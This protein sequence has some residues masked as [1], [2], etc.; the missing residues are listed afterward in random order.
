VE[1]KLN[2]ERNL[3]LVW[4]DP[5]RVEQVLV[6]LVG[7]AIRYTPAGHVEIRAWAEAPLLWV[8]IA[9]TGIG[10]A[11]EDLPLV[12]ERFWRADRSRDRQSGG[13][14]IGLAIS[15]RLVELQGG[16]IEVESELGVGSTFCFSL[17]VRA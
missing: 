2:A 16:T 1:L 15:R 17:P 14:G 11:A 8:A 4:A 12:F 5:A 3:P 9:D 6:N 10:I 7:N 13:T